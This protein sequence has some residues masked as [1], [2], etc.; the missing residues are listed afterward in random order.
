MIKQGHVIPFW[1][2]KHTLL[3]YK[4]KYFNDPTMIDQW[5]AAGYKGN[6]GGG[7]YDMQK[8]MPNWATPFFSIFSG[9]NVSITFFKMKISDILP[10]HVDTYQR[11]IKINNIENPH[12]IK[13]AIIFLDDWKPGHIFEIENQ[14]I[15]SWKAGDFVLWNYGAPHMAANIGIEPRYTLQITFVDNI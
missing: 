9:K 5:V 1:N 6:F 3:T 4:E 10:T 11:Y 14:P 15:T 2:N 13:R 7:T 12:T 8:K